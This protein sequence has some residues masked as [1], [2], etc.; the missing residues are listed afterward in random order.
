MKRMKEPLTLWLLMFLA[1]SPSCGPGLPPGASP[2]ACP[3][4]WEGAIPIGEILARPEAYLGREVVIVAYYRGWDWFGEVGHGP[5][6]TRSDVAVADAT[7]AIYIAPAGPEAL[8]WGPSL[9]PFDPA[10]TEILWRL[11]GTVERTPAGALYLRVAKGEAV[12][13]LPVG[14]L[15]R[16]RRQGGLA[17]FDQELMITEQGTLYLLDR[18]TRRAARVW[19]DP[20][21][22]RRVLGKLSALPE[23]GYGAPVPD[24][25]I[26]M[27][28]FWMGD[29]IRTFVLY[30]PSEGTTPAA[31]R[32]VLK[33]VRS[34][35][36]MGITP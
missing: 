22:A 33:A 25:F 20:L 35:L 3:P 18:R 10:S 19:I 34:W 36:A 23:A 14:V 5:P 24:G 31:A 32:E 16:I 27:L 11:R 17:G 26:Y 12:E 30:D 7:G 21:E 4:L 8:P 6:L 15:L 28:R 1:L 2:T 9:R 13:G 29:K